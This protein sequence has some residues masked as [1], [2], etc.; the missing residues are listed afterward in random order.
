M[1]S[2][3]KYMQITGHSTSAILASATTHAIQCSNMTIRTPLLFVIDNLRI[4]VRLFLYG[5]YSLFW[6]ML[7]IIEQSCW[8]LENWMYAYIQP[9]QDIHAVPYRLRVINFVLRQCWKLLMRVLAI[10]YI[11]YMNTGEGTYPFSYVDFQVLACT[12]ADGPSLDY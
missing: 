10:I 6:W 7:Q 1:R 5:A 4:I 12:D 9:A 3:L 2:S 8:N 11:C